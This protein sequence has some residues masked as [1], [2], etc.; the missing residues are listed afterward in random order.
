MFH[1]I[2]GPYVH[3]VELEA[4]RLIDRLIAAGPG[5]AVR[6]VRGAKM[7]TEERAFDEFAAAFQFPYYFGENW[8]AFAECINDLSWLPASRYLTVVRDA[9]LAMSQEQDRFATLVRILAEAG[10]S[11]A[12]VSP[13]ARPWAPEP[14]PFHVLLLTTP[15]HLHELSSLLSA[16]SIGFDRNSP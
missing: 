8:D 6:V 5:T 9:H 14:R 12:E 11:W 15:T 1:Q 2:T 13:T 16:A 3:V 10:R 4:A 7:L